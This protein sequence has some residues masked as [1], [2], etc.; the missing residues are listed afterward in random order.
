[1]IGWLTGFIRP[2]AVLAA[3]QSTAGMLNIFAVTVGLGYGWLLI[4]CVICVASPSRMLA[5]MTIIARGV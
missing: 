1:L 4:H 5:G 2:V 3:A